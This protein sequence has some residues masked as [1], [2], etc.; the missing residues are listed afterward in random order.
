[1]GTTNKNH[2]FE[3]FVQSHGPHEIINLMIIPHKRNVKSLSKFQ[4]FPR[5]KRRYR[6]AKAQW[7]PLKILFLTF[8]LHLLFSSFPP[9]TPH[10][11][12]RKRRWSRKRSQ[13]QA[14]DRVRHE[15]IIET[16]TRFNVDREDTRLIKDLYWQQ[17]ANVKINNKVIKTLCEIQKGTR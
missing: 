17:R 5:V 8:I 7:K 10:G 14:F 12:S 1:M 16:L 15:K 13:N 6:S 3:F 11:F 2:L 4:M 9:P